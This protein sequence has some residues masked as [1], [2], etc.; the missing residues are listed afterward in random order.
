MR[1]CFPPA[2]AGQP[3][4]VKDRLIL[5]QNA[6]TNAVKSM[7]LQMK[8]G[9]DFNIEE[10]LSIAREF[11]AYTSGD[12]D[13]KPAESKSEPSEEDWQEAAGKFRAAS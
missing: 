7:E 8:D 11:E 9:G 6:L 4:L 10:V 2:A 12:S 13:I 1:L 5:R 3:A